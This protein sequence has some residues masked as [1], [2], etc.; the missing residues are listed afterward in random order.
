MIMSRIVEYAPPELRCAQ[1]RHEKPVGDFPVVTARGKVRYHSYCH[2]CCNTYA[3]DHRAN[4]PDANKKARAYYRAN[5]EHKKEV[6]RQWRARTGHDRKQN[7]RSLYGLSVDD[8]RLLLTAQ[9]E[10]CAICKEPPRGKRKF[11][12]VDH[13]HET[14]Q[15]RGLLCTTCNVGMGALRDSP[16][17]LRTAAAYLERKVMP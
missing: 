6:A 7:L 17:L 1:C 15:V 11:L 3:K 5:V 10:V 14:G 4:D 12:S 16:E 8:Y 2:E 13:D 9:N